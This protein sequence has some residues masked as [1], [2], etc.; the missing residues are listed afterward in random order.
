MSD[1]SS[2]I[3]HINNLKHL[4]T[5][6]LAKVQ[7]F[8]DCKNNCV[9][10]TIASILNL[11]YGSEVD[12]AALAKSIDENWPKMPFL[13]RM[14]PNWATTPRQARRILQMLAHQGN[15]QIQTHLGVFSDEYLKNILRFSL[16]TYPILTFY[17]VS[18]G[19]QLLTQ[20]GNFELTMQ[21]NPGFGAHTM[22]LAAYNP[23]RV[24]KHGLPHPWGFINSWAD[25]TISD[26]FWM[27]EETWQRLKKLKTLLVTLT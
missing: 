17:W 20:R 13:Y 11:H 21:T 16:N 5:A 22:L 6:D 25:K 27:N 15:L 14:A 8:Q 12:G 19:P 4:P 23:Q 26:L 18:K 3:T 10:H 2:N 9:L 7:Q 24:D 1:S